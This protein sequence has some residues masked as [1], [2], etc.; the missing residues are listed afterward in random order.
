LIC[1]INLKENEKY[2]VSKWRYETVSA[3]LNVRCGPVINS[4]KINRISRRL[5][6]KVWRMIESEMPGVAGCEGEG[7]A[8]VEVKIVCLSSPDLQAELRMF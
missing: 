5:F 2:L 1:K 6:E 3:I 8:G 7:E 4:H